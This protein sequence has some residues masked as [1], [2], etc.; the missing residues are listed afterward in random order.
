[1]YIAQFGDHEEFLKEMEN[2][3]EMILYGIVRLTKLYRP[4]QP[5][6]LRSLFVV[7]TYRVRD[8]MVRLE[9]YVGIAPS[10]PGYNKEDVEEKADRI[11]HTIAEVAKRLGLDVRP[12][13]FLPCQKEEGEL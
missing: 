2:D 12:G 13:I 10:V 1:M 9:R 8:Y 11:I 6:P 7:A 3:R 5:P 4:M